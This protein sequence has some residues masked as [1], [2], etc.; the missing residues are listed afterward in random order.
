MPGRTKTLPA[1]ELLHNMHH[2]MEKYLRTDRLPHIWCSGCGLGTTL[3][4]FTYALDTLNLSDADVGIVSGIGCTGRAAG[5]LNLD[6]YHT[7][8]GRAIAFAT[9]LALARPEKK[10]VVISGD[11]DLFAIGG[12][13]FIHAARRNINMTVLCVNNFN[14]GM[15]GGQFGPTTPIGQRGTT[16][17]Y[18][19]FESPFNLPYLA[20]SSGAVYVARWTS[21]DAR[22]VKESFVEALQRPGFSFVEVVSP[23]PT[24][25][26]RRNRIGDGLDELRYYQEHTVIR[27]GS[28][29]KNADLEP[30]KEIVVGRFVDAPRPTYLELYN[31]WVLEKHSL[32]KTQT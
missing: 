8:H 19:N 32:Q 20:A 11:G 25:Y 27:H 15:T 31:T 30:G 7:T 22:R 18:G 12:N 16:A 28:D 1:P 21:L 24:N 17:P 29:P 26:G 3:S 23:C 4:C 2:P 13:H 9:G 10:V 6:S 5:Y 14:Y